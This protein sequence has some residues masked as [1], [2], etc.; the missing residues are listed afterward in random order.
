MA[1]RSCLDCWLTSGLLSH[2]HCRLESRN[3]EA[4]AWLTMLQ[5]HGHCCCWQPQRRA[6][7]TNCCAMQAPMMV[8]TRNLDVV[9]YP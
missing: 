3:Y 8:L 5:W 9:L 1:S 7:S 4:E 2:H 6:M